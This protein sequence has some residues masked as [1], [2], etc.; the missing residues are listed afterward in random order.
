MQGSRD[1]ELHKLISVSCAHVSNRKRNTILEVV[2]YSFKS[3]T[4]MPSNLFLTLLR[5]FLR[6][7]DSISCAVLDSSWFES[8]FRENQR[9][10]RSQYCWLCDIPRRIS[11][12]IRKTARMESDI[13]GSDYRTRAFSLFLLRF[14]SSPE[15]NRYEKFPDDLK[16]F[17][18]YA[19]NL[20][21][22]YFSCKR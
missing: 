4:I 9:L 7:I 6:S 13:I 2:S 12:A 20:L 22:N 10:S 15:V 14:A 5:C 16:F 21:F 17:E 1:V 8:R 11:F 19:R 18:I 3:S